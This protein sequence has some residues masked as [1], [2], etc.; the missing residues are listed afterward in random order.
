MGPPRST[1]AFVQSTTFTVWVLET[2][3]HDLIQLCLDKRVARAS[4]DLAG[5]RSAVLD[6]VK[7]VEHDIIILFYLQGLVIFFLFFIAGRALLINE[8]FDL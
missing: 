2:L 5:R 7:V 6:V 3:L 4:C 1:F 8:L